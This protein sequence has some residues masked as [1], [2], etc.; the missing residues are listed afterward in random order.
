MIKTVPIPLAGATGGHRS[1]QYGGE[2]TR[3]MY[4]DTTEGRIGAHDFPG[5]KI[6]GL[7]VV[8]GSD[9]GWHVMASVLYR[10]VNTYLYRVGQGGLYTQLGTIDGTDR[11]VFADD[12]TNLFIV[13]SGV[14]RHYNGSTVSTVTQTVVDNPQAITYINRQFIITGDG[15]LFAISNVGD[16]TTYNALNYAEDEVKPDVL[17]RPY[18]FT[19]VVYMMGSQ[20]VSLYYNS[21][22]GNPPLER[23]DSALVNIGLVGKHAVTSSDA[24]MYWLGD[25]RRVY[26]CI[27]ANARPVESPAFAHSVNQL[28]DVS[29]CVCSY[30]LLE[31]QVFILF[32]FSTETW[33]Y[34][35]T[36]NYWVQLCSGTDPNGGRW[37]GTSVI[38]CYG[39]NLV[40]VGGS[41]S[42]L[43]LNTYTDNTLP[44]LRIRTLPNLTGA[45]IGVGRKRITV[46]RLGI[47]MEVGVGLATGQGVNPKLM[48]QLSPDGGKTWQAQQTVS[49]GASGDYSLPVDFFDFCTGYEVRARI[50]CSEPVYMSIFDGEADISVAGY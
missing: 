50:M 26:Q 10:V 35:E 8:A 42:E 31:G 14:I 13:A 9:R 34:S 44:R 25:D 27:G 38:A 2:L 22:V 46:S 17:V 11:C 30:F 21:G 19:Q 7:A 45:L 49:M 6:F 29:D 23:K 24:Y 4:L 41:I 1:S 5:L 36:G 15:G 18:A 16:G 40:S 20:A 37:Y 43:D 48:C 33:L 28:D 3:N 39:A 12:G 47:N 32:S